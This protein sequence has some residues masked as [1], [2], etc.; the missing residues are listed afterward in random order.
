[1]VGKRQT[2]ELEQNRRLGL[3]RSA[4]IPPGFLLPPSPAPSEEVSFF[5]N[6][7]MQIDL[8]VAL[9]KSSKGSKAGIRKGERM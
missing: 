3:V 4:Q 9:T 2:A 5:P 8:I 6:A 1:M 7:F